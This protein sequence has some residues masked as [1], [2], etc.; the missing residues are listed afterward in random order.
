MTGE[1]LTQTVPLNME[2]KQTIQRSSVEF[3]M[4]DQTIKFTMFSGLN[5]YIVNYHH[6]EKED[7]ER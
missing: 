3:L 5:E 7:E 2:V 4:L 6:E 1:V